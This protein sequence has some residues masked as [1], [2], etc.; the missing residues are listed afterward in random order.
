MKRRRLCL[1]GQ[2][3]SARTQKPRLWRRRVPFQVL[4]DTKIEALQRWKS[5]IYTEASFVLLA[6]KIRNHAEA[7]ERQNRRGKV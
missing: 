7:G 1:F 6:I 3:L 4:V 2:L 5:R